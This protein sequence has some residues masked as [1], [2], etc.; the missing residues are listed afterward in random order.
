MSPNLRRTIMRKLVW[1]LWF[2]R[3]STAAGG[4]VNQDTGKIGLVLKGEAELLN[5]E[6]HG[7]NSQ[8]QVNEN[9]IG[10]SPSLPWIHLDLGLMCL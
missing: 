4:K 6:Q 8:S 3:G 10:S 5:C 1:K 9:E 7:N 2:L